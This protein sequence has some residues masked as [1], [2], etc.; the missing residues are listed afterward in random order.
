MTIMPDNGPLTV[1]FH[2]NHEAIFVVE[3]PHLAAVANIC[4][5]SKS[6]WSFTFIANCPYDDD[7]VDIKNESDYGKKT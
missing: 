2:V 3:S 1:G 7:A 6:R 4:V 5:C